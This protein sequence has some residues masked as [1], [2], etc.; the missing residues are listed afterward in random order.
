MMLVALRGVALAIAVLAMIDPS[1]QSM[2]QRP[3]AVR[4]QIVESGLLGVTAGRGG[5][6]LE[7]AESIKRRLIE[8]LRGAID[9]SD[10]RAPAAIVL[11]GDTPPDAL[12]VEDVPISTVL[13]DDDGSPNVRILNIA[14]PPAAPIR[15]ATLVDAEFE[16]IG[17]RGKS[18][19]IVL[20]D[21]PI[22]GAKLEHRWTRERE[23]F[24]AALRY[25]APSTGIRRITV[26]AEPLREETTAFD[27]FADSSLLVDDRPL[28]VLAFE[29]RPSWN[30]TFVRRALE[31]DHRF[32]VASAVR[33]SRGVMVRNNEAPPAL[34]PASVDDFDVVVVGA[35]EELRREEVDALTT[36]ADRRG[37]AVVF[38][39]DRR[40]SGRYADLLPARGFEEMLVENAV[41]L[42]AGASTGVRA[43]ELLVAQ[44]VSAAAST[45]AAVDRLGARA[46]VSL[47]WPRGAG[48]MLL[49]GAL[50][51]WRF[52]SD[53]DGAFS[54]Y[55]QA[56]VAELAMAAPA[57]IAV[58][59]SPRLAVPNERVV[60][61]AA[62][63][64]TEFDANADR[65]VLPGIGAT[66]SNDGGRRQP[67]RLWPTAELGVFEGHAAGSM[68]GT[69]DV[70]VTA[71]THVGRASFTVAEA[72]RRAPAGD[73]DGLNLIA[74]STGGIA[75]R[76][77]NVAPLD[78]HLRNL[79]GE[80]EPTV[81]RPM[82]SLW[83]LMP[84][85]ACLCAEW[86]LRRR[87]GS[88]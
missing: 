12:P 41:T 25:A 42:A 86:A 50:D 56:S 59:I 52:R 3:P 32:N 78:S 27:N 83:W 23:R 30:A 21:G 53:G 13:L 67:V 66:L 85:A 33:S 35:P 77:D 46:P 82:R 14:E 51:A 10:L 73:A 19:T 22:V 43:S 60:I 65:V 7:R 6:R 58:T 88:R 28:R 48:R 64:S 5:I 49:W 57:R 1:E 84:F 62:L 4:I 61:R 70:E 11:I 37:G 80:S 29:P 54:R 87:R 36:F 68:T 8:N 9:V 63:R 71:A 40:P 74:A 34:T 45:V 18:S 79:G 69:Y 15:Q 16:A 81:G 47:T 20:R 75:V 2:R 44:R 38:V 39:P 24:R 72:V 17:M 26:G 76:A 55:W 31:A